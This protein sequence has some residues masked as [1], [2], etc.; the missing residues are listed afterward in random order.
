MGFESAS[1]IP[2]LVLFGCWLS[3]NYFVTAADLVIKWN[4]SLSQNLQVAKEQT[5]LLGQ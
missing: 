5:R 4:P 1:I 3:S 2:S